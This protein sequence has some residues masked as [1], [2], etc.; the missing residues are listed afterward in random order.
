MNNDLQSICSSCD[1]C[2]S[3]ARPSHP[4]VLGFGSINAKLLILDTSYLQHDAAPKSLIDFT[5]AIP[6][7]FYYSKVTRCAYDEQ[8]NEEQLIE[9]LGACSVWTN[10]IAANRDVIVLTKE[11]FKQLRIEEDF[12]NGRIIQSRKWGYLLCIPPIC[13]MDTEVPTYTARLERILRTK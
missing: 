1:V 12:E 7:D 5:G 6:T 8:P 13:T 10:C 4:P 3:I 2:Q 11:G 9:M